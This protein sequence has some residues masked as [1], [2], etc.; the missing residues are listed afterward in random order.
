[1]KI[2]TIITELSLFLIWGMLAL[3][4]IFGGTAWLLSTL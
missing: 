2:K 3:F 1:M 4:V